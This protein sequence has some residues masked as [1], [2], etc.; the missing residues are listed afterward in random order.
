MSLSCSCMQKGQGKRLRI[1]MYDDSSSTYIYS[2]TFLVQI[3]WFTSNDFQISRPCPLG[4][5][6]VLL[7]E[8]SNKTWDFLNAAEHKINS[9]N[10]QY[11]RAKKNETEKR[12]EKTEKWNAICRIALGAAAWGTWAPRL[13]VHSHCGMKQHIVGDPYKY[14]RKNVICMSYG[15]FCL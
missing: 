12:R 8:S 1:K 11:W 7:I 4:K 9:Q 15:W 2:Q 5:I 6:Q 3:R 14:T 13:S 10:A